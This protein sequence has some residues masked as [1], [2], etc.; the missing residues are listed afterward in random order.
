MV[1]HVPEEHGVG[2]SSPPLGTK[3]KSPPNGG[4]FSLVLTRFNSQLSL[5]VF[6]DFWKFNSE[7]AVPFYGFSFFNL[8][9]LR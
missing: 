6:V 8:N 4:D 3:I 9:L 7:E 5:S 2:G 1:E